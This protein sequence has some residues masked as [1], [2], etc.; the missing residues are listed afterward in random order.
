[1]YRDNE[2]PAF[3]GDI[4]WATSVRMDLGQLAT[5]HPELTPGHPNV[6]GGMVES[7]VKIE[8]GAIILSQFCLALSMTEASY[9]NRAD[10]RVD[11]C[12]APEMNDI[13][14]LPAISPVQHPALLPDQQSTYSELS[15]N[16]VYMTSLSAPLSD[17][18]PEKAPP[19]AERRR[20]EK[21]SIKAK[22]KFLKKT[23]GIPDAVAG[24][25]LSEA[26][27]LQSNPV[28][29]DTTIYSKSK[30]EEHSG[31]L[32]HRTP[33]TPP[34]SK[35]GPSKPAPQ[36]RIPPPSAIGKLG[37]P[38]SHGS[39]TGKKLGLACLFCRERKIACGRPSESN[40]DQTCNQC[41]RRMFKCEYPTESRRGQH[42]RPKNKPEQTQGHP[43]ARGGMVESTVKV[44]DGA[45][46]SSQFCLA[47]SMTEASYQNRA[48]PRVGSCLALEMNDISTLP[49][50]S[51]V[52]HPVLLPDQQSTYSEL[53]A[54]LVYMTSLPAPLSDDLPEKAPPVIE[55]RRKEKMSIKAKEKFLKKTLGIPDAVAG[56]LLSE[57][58][59][60]QSNPVQQ[61]TTIYSKSKSEEHSG[62][63]RHRT[64]FT[65]PGSKLGPS[66]PAPQKRIP[67]PSAI[68]KLGIPSSHG[69][70]T[71]KKLGLA[72]LFCRER[73]IACGRPSESNPDQTC[74]QCARRMFKCEYPTESRRGQHKRP[75]NKP[76]VT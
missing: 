9:Q 33:F 63:L 61:D 35:L 28:Q 36:K 1:M 65:P 17:Y 52:Q 26:D 49:A 45:I 6:R 7:T 76:E 69:S 54:N 16:L 18:L 75:K 15:A 55:R 53:S 44:E 29:Q 70:H 27:S 71:G 73:K 23:L 2:T 20:K 46:I 21:M 24:A 13:S 12:L 41:A 10:P 11:S 31:K 74:N 14:T 5:V 8:D 67:P 37:I 66:K 4:E 47:L 62:K 59:S 60:L 42:K 43:N 50:I 68:G 39:H 34:G 58:D 57:A 19:V 64:P 48:D 51:P 38:S 25:L 72:C 22:E 30:S 32:R 3:T 56:A 40:P